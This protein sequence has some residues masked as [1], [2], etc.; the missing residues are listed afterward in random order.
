MQT[1][2]NGRGRLCPLTQIIEL[3]GPAR[4]VH[5]PLGTTRPIRPRRTALSPTCTL[6]RPRH[7]AR[8]RVGQRVVGELL[9]VTATRT[10]AHWRRA[11]GARRPLGRRARSRGHRRG[12]CSAAAERP[13]INGLATGEPEELAG[14]VS[15]SWRCW[16]PARGRR[17]P[18]SADPVGCRPPGRPLLP[19]RSTR[20]GLR[21]SPGARGPG[22]LLR[23]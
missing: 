14:G 18:E 22:H 8:G 15:V 19:G 17:L 21:L 23:D 13:A 1:P 6:C 4:S 16:R 11:A 5:A 12:C 9:K 2:G 10:R 20:A 7:M 3:A